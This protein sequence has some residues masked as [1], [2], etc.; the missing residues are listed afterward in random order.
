MK[1][2]IKED[3]GNAPKKQFIKD[4][5]VAI[6]QENIKTVMNMVS[7]DICLEIIGYQTA[8]GKQAVQLLFEKNAQPLNGR[9]LVIDTILSHGNRGAANGILKYKDGRTVDF[10]TLYTF[11]SYSKNAKLQVIQT[12]SITSK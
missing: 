2:T 12:Y 8:Q 10:C 7:D 5:F 3:C 6:A 9:E 4:F 1:I 11:D